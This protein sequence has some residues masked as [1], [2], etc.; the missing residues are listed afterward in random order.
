MKADCLV[1]A[2]LSRSRPCCRNEL[3]GSE[4]ALV[5]GSELVVVGGGELA[6]TRQRAHPRGR[7]RAHTWW[8]DLISRKVIPSP[9][10]Q[11]VPSEL[12]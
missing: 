3:A 9:L 6:L 8:Y 11:R 7:W 12:T 5:E 2:S 1:V 4:L 10:S